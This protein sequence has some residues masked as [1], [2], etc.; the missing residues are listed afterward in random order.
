MKR[1]KRAFV[2]IGFGSYRTMNLYKNDNGDVFISW[3]GNFAV[4]EKVPGLIN[5]WRFVY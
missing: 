2:Y 5:F 4:V 1:Y 3:E